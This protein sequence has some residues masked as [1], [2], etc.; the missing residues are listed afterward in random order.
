MGKSTEDSYRR[1]N[2]TI[3]DSRVEVPH[4]VPGRRGVQ[5]DIASSPH[6]RIGRQLIMCLSSGSNDDLQDRNLTTGKVI[7]TEIKVPEIAG[8]QQGRANSANHYTE[9]VLSD[10]VGRG[11]GKD[12]TAGY[13]VGLHLDT[14]TT[15]SPPT[16]K[17]P[18]S[19]TAFH[20]T[21]EYPSWLTSTNGYG[22]R[23]EGA[24]RFKIQTKWIIAPLL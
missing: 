19:A 22:Y 3:L 15:P 5:A 12:L 14:A 1:W 2:P 16:R 13:V 7:I 18:S 17:M 24:P 8:K 11:R 21:C 6:K 9:Y 20:G 23:P 10:I 4:P